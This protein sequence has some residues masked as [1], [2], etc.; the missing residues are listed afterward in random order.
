[1]S[2]RGELVMIRTADGEEPGRLIAVPL[3]LIPYLETLAE[4]GAFG[5]GIETVVAS[6][7]TN[8]LERYAGTPMLDTDILEEKRRELKTRGQGAALW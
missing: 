6:M 4:C 3:R 1:M 8:Q 5:P 2:E 7:I